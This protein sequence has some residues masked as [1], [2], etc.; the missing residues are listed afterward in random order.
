MT[1][2]TNEELWQTVL[3]Q[4]QFSVSLANFATWFKNTKIISTKNGEATICVQN[5][6]A[7]EWISNKYS[8]LILKILRNL[9]P[10]IKSLNFLINTKPQENILIT[11][12]NQ[13]LSSKEEGD[14]V[15]SARLPIQEF[16]VNKQTN[17]NPSYSFDNFI[18]GNFNQMAHAAACAITETPISI[19]NPLF[20]YGGVGLGK[21]HL[22]QATGNKIAE[23]FPDKKI[24]Y[25]SCERLVSEII[26]AIK[27]RRIAEFKKESKE[28]DVFIVDD[29]QFFTGKEK[30]QEEFFHIFNLLYHSQ[31]QIILSCDTSPKGI[32]ALE[33]RLRSRFEGGMLVDIGIPDIETR[34]A[35]LKAKAKEKNFELEDEILEYISSSIRDNI[36]ELEGA[37]NKLLFWKKM[38]NGIL[39]LEIAKKL[40]KN[41]VL[42]PKKKTNFKNIIQTIGDFYNLTEKE[43]LSTSRRKEIVKP[44]QIVMYLLRE[45]LNESFPSIGRKFNGKDHTTVMY[46]WGKINKEI[47]EDDNLLLELNSI[48]QKLYNINT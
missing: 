18:V 11:T 10:E 12:K 48:K 15:V 2:L 26:D 29:I 43:L 7:K 14:E 41:L 38:N 40:L 4:V 5:S 31:K 17:L 33:K 27:N 6:F 20:V 47:K 42:F 1:I 9:D 44:R 13:P 37:L 28:I 16:S 39:N 35:I 8:S 32:S 3:A 22:I 30:S 36:R 21:T 45:E 46:S 34:I 25:I 24:K 19:Y 23:T